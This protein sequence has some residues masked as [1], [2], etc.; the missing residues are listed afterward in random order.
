MMDGSMYVVY[1]QPESRVELGVNRVNRVN[2]EV[3]TT[4]ETL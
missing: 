3:C 1:L 2:N 4:Y